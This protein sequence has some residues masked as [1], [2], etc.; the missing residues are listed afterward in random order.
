[1]DGITIV[2]FRHDLRLADNPALQFACA[3]GR[4]VLPVYV[5]CRGADP[6]WPVGGAGRVWLHHSLAALAEAL[7][8][9][10]ARLIIREGEPGKVLQQL[11]DETGA[12]QIAWNRLYEPAIIQRDTAIKARL[13]QQGLTVK[14]FNASVL[15]EPFAI[16][17]KQ[18][19]PFKVFTPFWRH[20]QRLEPVAAPLPRVK[21]IRPPAIPINTLTLTELKLLPVSGW[22]GSIMTHWQPGCEQAERQLQRFLGSD[23]LAAYLDNRDFPGLAGVSKLSPYLH[24]GE[25]SSRQVW[26]GVHQQA[27]ATGQL[28]PSKQAAG[29]IRQLYWR[30][31]AHHLLYHFPDT[32]AHPLNVQY[33]R[34]P[35]R[36]D[37]CQLRAWQQGR[38]G[39]PLVDAGMRQLWH[40]GWMHNRVRMVVGSFLVKDLLLPWQV[41]A[42]WF[43][44]TLVDADL[45]NNTLGW[46]WV[47]GCG[48][49]A[50]PY[51]RIF[52]PVLQSQKFDAD[53]TY[54]RTWLPELAHLDARHIHAPW[55][56]DSSTLA[57]AGITLGEDYPPPL[58]DHAHARQ[59]ALAALA[60]IKT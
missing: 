28:S 22:H 6:A 1:M 37:P 13:E 33:R 59:A 17:N 20:C 29:Y 5:L 49:D 25:I 53:G 14:T 11:V 23:A 44:D 50:A 34:F 45:A 24:F 47:A 21:Q 7:M 60:S 3:G 31:F 51:F 2:W 19:Q 41:G 55:Q 39:Y 36:D 46:Q 4:S 35:W 40:S 52:N 12:T 10:G 54:I 57:R 27:R 9:A 26:H 48:A 58:V 38:T 43:W 8:Q 16:H 18:G 56:A 15:C 42:A 32:P 30:E